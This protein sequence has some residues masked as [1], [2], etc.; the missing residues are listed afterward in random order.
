L[1]QFS[2][3]GLPDKAVE[4]ARDRVS[5]AVKNAGL[6]PPKQLNQKITIALAPAD[7]RKEGAIYDVP[8]ALAYLIS[9]KELAFNPEGKIFVGE[10]ALD[11]KLRP[12]KGVLNIALEAKRKGMTELYVPKEN[13]AEATLVDGITVF[14]VNSLLQLI[15][16][17][18]LDENTVP[19]TPQSQVPFPNNLAHTD[20][21]LLHIRGQQ[22]AKRGLLIA[23]AGGHNIALWGPPGTGKTLLARAFRS[24]LPPLN[25]QDAIEVT[26]IHSLSGTLDGAVISESPFRSPHHTASYVSIIGGGT[27]PKPGEVTLAHHGVLFL[28]EFP[29]FD[30][31]VLESLRQ[32][33]E[34]GVVH[35]A[36]AKGTE[37]FPAR[38][39]LVA[40]M[41]PCPC[42]YYGDSKK[43]CVCAPTQRER[44]QRK[45]SGPIIDRIDI[46]IEVP[47]ITHSE[48]VPSNEEPDF[49]ELSEMKRTIDAARNIQQ[50]RFLDR[51]VSLNAHM[52]V[53]EIDALIQLEQAQIELLTTS[54]QRL[55]LSPRAFHRIIKLARTIADIEQSDEIGEAHILEALQYRPKRLFA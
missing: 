8:I 49:G 46:W 43:A 28:D 54:A 35:V 29:E 7:I 42:G 3:V 37:K 36:R 14:P 12:I 52:G 55:D 38:F 6:K 17:L 30:K 39:L 18:T 22:T 41:N 16:H 26:S 53:K 5:A 45:I 48:L 11:G 10:L 20:E 27:I 2:V 34:E 4:E 44:Y 25:K 47:R 21:S 24:L 23:A 1:H 19:I 13:A 32:P 15:T 51:P 40:A 50:Q 9:I 33:L 31:R